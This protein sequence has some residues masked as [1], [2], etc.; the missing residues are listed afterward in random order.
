[1]AERKS[2]EIFSGYLA[3]IEKLQHRKRIGEV[4]DWVIKNFPN[5]TPKI[6]WNQ[7]VF[8]DHGTFIIGFSAAKGHLAAAPE[9]A[10]ILRFSGDIQ[11]AGY[12]HS[13]E[14]IRMKWDS[15]VNYSLLA[16]IIAF[17]ISDKADCKT[18]WRKA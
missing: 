4:L 1:M 14:L 10:C 6:A 5:L 9:K 8:T 3:K 13:K 15:P 11:Q 7:P 12:E 17:N 16:K 18:F 2:I